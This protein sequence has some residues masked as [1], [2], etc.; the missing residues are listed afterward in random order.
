MAR[1]L[2]LEIART[3]G[4]L[5]VVIAAAVIPVACDAGPDPDGSG[6][7]GASSTTTIATAGS[8]S[9]ST[10][11]FASSS[12]MSSTGVGGED[13][14]GGQTETFVVELPPAGTP[15]EPGQICAAAADPVDSAASARVTLMMGAEPHLAV[16]FIAVPAEIEPSI[17]GTPTVEA[18]EATVTDLLPVDIV[19]VTK[20]AGGYTFD[21]TFPTPFVVDPRSWARVTFRVTMSLDCSPAPAKTV[22]S[23]TYVQLCD[24]LGGTLWVSSGDECNVCSIIA[25]MAPSPIVPERRADDL[26]LAFAVRLRI[27]EIARIGRARVL[28]A[29]NDG[30]EG[31]TYRWRASS[32]T[33]TE[34]SADV[35]LWEPPADAGPHQLQA[36]VTGEDGAAVSSF[37]VKEV[38]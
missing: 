5:P 8:G 28:F 12:S 27:V 32:G 31:M 29:E 7:G 17:V 37:L 11:L 16:G 24:E 33:L 25:E 1:R 15:A 34:L 10:A 36:A 20:T 38:A 18:I 22:R 30:G 14:C 19:N 3:P 13:F 23:I 6:A 35:V 26:G 2:R 4:K 9:T 21:A